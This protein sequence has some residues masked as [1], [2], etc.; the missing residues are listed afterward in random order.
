LQVNFS[1]K[2]FPPLDGESRIAVLHGQP[3]HAWLGLDEKRVTKEQLEQH[4]GKFGTLVLIVN[5]KSIDLP[6]SFR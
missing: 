6:L 5:G 2:L 4:R 3:F 1:G